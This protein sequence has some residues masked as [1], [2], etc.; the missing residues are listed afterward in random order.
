VP[1]CVW[2]WSMNM[3]IRVRVVFWRAREPHLELRVAVHVKRG[4]RIFRSVRPSRHIRETLPCLP[5]LE[6]DASRVIIACYSRYI[7]WAPTA[8]PAVQMAEWLTHH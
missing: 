1:S 7:D 3:N 2:N 8:L 4:D 6:R 5:T